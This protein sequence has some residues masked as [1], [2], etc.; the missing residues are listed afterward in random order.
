MLIEIGGWV[1][2]SHMVVRVPQTLRVCGFANAVSHPQEVLTHPL[3]LAVRLLK[4]CALNRGVSGTIYKKKNLCA[5][6]RRNVI[7]DTPLHRVHDIARVACH[8]DCT[9]F[10]WEVGSNLVKMDKKNQGKM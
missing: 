3:Q 7:R 10:A 8:V 5:G 6:Q 2:K 9:K 1:E 4:V